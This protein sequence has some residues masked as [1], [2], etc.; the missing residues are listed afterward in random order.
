MKKLICILLALSLFAAPAYAQ[1]G[2]PLSSRSQPGEEIRRPSDN[3]IRLTCYASSTLKADGK[4]T[5]DAK[6]AF[7]ND[8][9]TAWVEGIKG[10]GFYESLTVV[11]N[12]PILFLGFSIF[13]GYGKSNDIYNKNERVAR[14]EVYIDDEW[15]ETF[16]LQDVQQWQYCELDESVVGNEIEFVIEGVY[17]GSKYEDTCISEIYLDLG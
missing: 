8:L 3:E 2:T 17:P 9:S 11:S 12:V 7:D 1:G 13:A 4:I 14:L 16:V 15:V 10:S 6:N 5:Y